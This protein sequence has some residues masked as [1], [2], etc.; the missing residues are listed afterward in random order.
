M[1]EVLL[2]G[3]NFCLQAHAGLEG[4]ERLISASEAKASVRRPNPNIFSPLR[5]QPLIISL[6]SGNGSC[7]FGS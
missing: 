5:V 4:C 2:Q 7:H 3:L 1:N 6:S